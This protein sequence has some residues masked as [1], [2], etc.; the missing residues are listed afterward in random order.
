M[1]YQG[2]DHQIWDR[3]F[4]RSCRNRKTGNGFKQNK[5]IFRI[6]FMMKWN[7]FYDEGG[8]T[9]TGWP[10]YARCHISGNN[11]NAKSLLLNREEN[12]VTKFMTYWTENRN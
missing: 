6:Y 5:G 9:V 2:N 10:E 1:A 4:S 11:Q 8:N 7:I 12:L 3:L